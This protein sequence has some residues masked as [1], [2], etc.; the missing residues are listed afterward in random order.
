MGAQNHKQDAVLIDE[1]ARLYYAEVDR[2]TDA[3]KLAELEAGIAKVL[4]DVRAAVE[5]WH[6][7]QARMLNVA[8]GLESARA[9]VPDAE[10]EEGRAFIAWFLNDHFTFLGCRDYELATVK[11]EDV[12]RIV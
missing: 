4:V 9:G 1:F 11:G 3:V 5:D 8:G 10:L 6:S 2:E 7:M 12:L